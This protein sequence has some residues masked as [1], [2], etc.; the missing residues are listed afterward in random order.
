MAGL[1]VVVEFPQP[2]PDLGILDADYLGQQMRHNIAKACVLINFIAVY[3]IYTLTTHIFKSNEWVLE[4]RVKYLPNFSRGRRRKLILDV[5]VVNLY[6][7]KQN[8]MNSEALTIELDV[9]KG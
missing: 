2:V 4:R 8:Q 1:H 5:R 7:S 9:E 3:H 6:L